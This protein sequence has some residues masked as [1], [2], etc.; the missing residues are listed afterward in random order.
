MIQ[1]RTQSK[2]SVML[3]EDPQRPAKGFKRL[4]FFDTEAEAI[5]WRDGNAPDATV[6]ECLNVHFS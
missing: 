3:I 5:A 1:T 6:H 4:G 2:W